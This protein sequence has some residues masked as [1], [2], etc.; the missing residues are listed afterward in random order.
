VYLN[1]YE[2]TAN[3][4]FLAVFGSEYDDKLEWIIDFF[5]FRS[6]YHC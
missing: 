1:E 3:K 4:C 2:I 6:T 5:S